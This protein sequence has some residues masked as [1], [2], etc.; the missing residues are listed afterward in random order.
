VASG[1]L[2]LNLTGGAEP[3]AG[4]NAKILLPSGVHVTGISQG[5]ILSAGFTLDWRSVPGTSGNEVTIIA[6]SGTDTCTAASGVLLILNLQVDTGT[7]AGT[8]PVS[9]ASTNPDPLVNSRY[10]LSN[11]D[12]TQSVSLSTVNGTI[13]IGNDINDSDSDGMS[14]AWENAHGFSP[15]NPSD[16]SI[17]SDGDGFTNY[18]EY[19]AGTDPRDPDSHPV[20]F[21]TDADG[22]PNLQDNCPNKPNGPNFGTCSATSDKPGIN[23]TSD[24]DC[25]SGCSSNGLCLKNQ[26]D[27]DGDGVGDA[28]DN[29]P[30]TCNPEQLDAN[31][32]GI[33]DLCDLDPGCGGCGAPACEPPCS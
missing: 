9:F 25:A 7:T 10:A 22:V 33:G 5:A 8:Y 12:G 15:Y 29:C 1:P 24:T 2:T 28:C 11:A 23:C 19:Q 18:Q 21:D 17:D 16:A 6:Y 27:T 32:N 3:Y 14:D 26:E 4:V 31:G 13:N 20:L 30:T